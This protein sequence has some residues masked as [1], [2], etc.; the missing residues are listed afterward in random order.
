MDNPHGF[1]KLFCTFITFS[2]RDILLHVDL[3]FK[4]IQLYYYL[5]SF[6]LVAIPD[7]YL[8]SFLLVAIPDLTSLLL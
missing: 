7:Y 3:L 4:H 2:N 8:Q 5:Q 1:D 6:L